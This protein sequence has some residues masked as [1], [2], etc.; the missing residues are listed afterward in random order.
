M[1]PLPFSALPGPRRLPI[2]G[3]ML[4]YTK[5][6]GCQFDRLHQAKFRLRQEYGNI[7]REKL[8]AV[9]LVQLFQ[10]E[11]FERVYQRDGSHP[12]RP[13]MPLLRHRCK[14]QR[15]DHQQL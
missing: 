6:G 14:Y 8:G 2:L 5:A 1:K 9:D 12:E 10:P 15:Y 7:Y 11:D 13:P 3:S 4:M